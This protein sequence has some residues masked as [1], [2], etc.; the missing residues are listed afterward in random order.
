[1]TG[2]HPSFHCGGSCG[3][4][5]AGGSH[6]CSSSSQH[7]GGLWGRACLRS[8]AE[9]TLPAAMT[10]CAD[11]QQREIQHTSRKCSSAGCFFLPVVSVFVF[12][13]NPQ[14]FDLL[15]SVFSVLSPL[16]CFPLRTAHLFTYRTDNCLIDIV[17]IEVLSLNLFSKNTY[18]PFNHLH[19][20]KTHTWHHLK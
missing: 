15:P 11:T 19:H 7:H 13:R 6:D 3:C 9:D 8:A 14:L 10:T 18:C 2:V 5:R 20:S 1:M 12:E 16:D 4:R 17:N